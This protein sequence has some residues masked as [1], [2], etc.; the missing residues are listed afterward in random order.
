[1]PAD[2]PNTASDRPR[3][4]EQTVFAVDIGRQLM[5]RAE[6]YHTA[7]YNSPALRKMTILVPLKVADQTF[8]KTGSRS[9][10]K[11][12]NF[13]LV[14]VTDTG[15]SWVPQ[16]PWVSATARVVVAFN[17]KSRPGLRTS[18][19][20]SVWKVT[21]AGTAAMRAAAWDYIR[22]VP[23]ENVIKVTAGQVLRVAPDG[24]GKTICQ[25]I[26]QDW[27]GATDEYVDAVLGQL[28]LAWRVAFALGYRMLK[29]AP[30]DCLAVARELVLVLSSSTARFPALAMLAG[31]P[32]ALVVL[33][34]VALTSVPRELWE[35]VET[36]L[37]N[38]SS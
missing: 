3:T 12:H 25:V 15:R 34:Q 7:V 18:P 27:I 37:R 31:S 24:M 17:V 6:D 14:P 35:A 5:E 29:C 23:P 1:M 9:I 10:H 22:W 26:T 28:Y 38:S 16:A 30:D 8:T 32:E 19:F 13:P 11:M 20:A 33:C 2:K 36:S 4:P 21:A